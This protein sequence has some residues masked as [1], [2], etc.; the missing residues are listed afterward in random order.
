M[1]RTRVSNHSLFHYMYV[2]LLCDMKCTEICRLQ[3]QRLFLACTIACAFVCADP[4]VTTKESA[5]CF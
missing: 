3:L 5:V 2:E 1:F 4:A